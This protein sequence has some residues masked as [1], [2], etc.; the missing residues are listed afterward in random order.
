M[1]LNHSERIM[2]EEVGRFPCC[3]DEGNRYI[4]VKRQRIVIHR[5]ISGRS[6]RVGGAIDFIL[7]DGTHLNP[8]DDND[9][10]FE[11]VVSGLRLTRA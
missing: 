10:L 6:Q 7:A 5:P 4:V 8:L 3:D 1:P 2:F 9:Q 11:I